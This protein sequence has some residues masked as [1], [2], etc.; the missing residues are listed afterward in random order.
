[1]APD[2][3]SGKV[4][5][6]GLKGGFSLCFQGLKTLS[7]FLARWG[8]GASKCGKV[9]VVGVLLRLFVPKFRNVDQPDVIDLI[10]LLGIG[11]KFVFD[12]D[13]ISSASS[14]DVFKL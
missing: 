11:E 5:R 8:Q 14:G 3:R 6:L 10:A 4:A 7:K 12:E 1:M 2:V 9:V 13:S